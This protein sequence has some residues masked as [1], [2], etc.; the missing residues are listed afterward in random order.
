M[1]NVYGGCFCRGG[2]GFLFFNFLLNKDLSKH[3]LVLD[4]NNI[5]Y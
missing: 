5:L 4:C 3:S 2:S 1:T